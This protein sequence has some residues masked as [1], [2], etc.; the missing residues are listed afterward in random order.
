MKETV[1]QLLTAFVA[2]LG[3]SLVSGLRSRHLSFAALGG[4]LAWGLYLLLHAMIPNV[5]LPV[6]FTSVAAVIYS[7]LMARWRK[8]PSTVFLMPTIIPLVPGSSLYYA[9]SSV[10]QGEAAAAKSYGRETLVWALAI[11]AGISFATALREVR[12]LKA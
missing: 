8:C 2:A 3:F 1:I 5:F 11:A 7:E 12:T 4:M 6:L 9:M 10:V